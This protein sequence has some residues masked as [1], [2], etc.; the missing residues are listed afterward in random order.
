MG[1]SMRL[2]AGLHAWLAGG[3]RLRFS[4]GGVEFTQYAKG[5]GLDLFAV[6][7]HPSV[8]TF[9]PDPSPLDLERHL[10]WADANLV[11]GE[12]L[13]FIVR[14]QQQPLGFI[15]LKNL[16]AAGEIEVGVI[17]ID[18]QQRTIV[19]ALACVGAAYLALEVFGGK[20]LVTYANRS[21][22]RALRL[23]RGMGLV[24]GESDKPHE[25]CF[26]T[27]RDVVRRVPA[28]VRHAAAARDSLQILG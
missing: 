16:P 12:T 10:A 13:L 27:P 9:M 3:R 26:R 21:H 22:A 14:R 6:R 20:V 24:E 28:Y 4:M 1:E 7:N 23:N 11:G 2:E 19:P 17:F 25:A 5:D 15:V 18:L 8:R